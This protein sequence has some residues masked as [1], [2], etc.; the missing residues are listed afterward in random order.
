VSLLGRSGGSFFGVQTVGAADISYIYDELG[1]LRAVVDPNLDTAVYNY[2]AVGN[3]LSITRQSSATVSIIEFTPDSGPVGTTVTIFGTGFSATPSQNSVT[4]NGISASVT[5]STSTQIVTP[6][7][8]GATT[9]VI[10]V[11]TPG[12]SATSAQVFTVTS[13]TGAPTITGFTPTIGLA[14]T[15][16]TVTGTN[17]EIVPSNNVLKFNQTYAPVTSPTTTSLGTT[18]PYYTASGPI[19]VTTPKGKAVS[20]SDFFI[21]PAPYTASDVEYT[22]RIVLDGPS[23]TATINTANKVGLVV[24]DA[25]AGQTVS[26]GVNSSTLHSSSKLKLYNPNGI[27]LADNGVLLN[28]NV[29]IHL[30][31]AVTGTYTIL[32]DPFTTNTGSVTLTLSSEVNAGTILVD[33]ASVTATINRVGQR[34]RMTFSGTAGQFVSLGVN[35]STLFNNSDLY[36]Y[37]PDGSTL[38]SSS[39]LN[40]TNNFHLTLPAT[41]TYTIIVDPDQTSTGSVTLTLSSEVDAG[42]IVVDG[43]SVAATMNRVGQRARMTFSGTVGQVASLGINSTTLSTGTDLFVLKPDGTTLASSTSIT[44]TSTNFHLTLPATGTYNILIDPDNTW[45]GNM[46]LTLSSEVNVG[47]LTINDPAVPVTISRVGQRARATFSGTS[48]QQV[49]ARVTGSTMGSVTVQMLKPD[50]T[51]QTTGTSPASS[52]NLATQTLGTTGTYTILVDPGST[53]TG[54]LNLRVT[55]P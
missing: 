33:G 47:V 55:S 48:G 38:S 1:R 40:T 18:V 26:L 3:L 11:T 51:Q 44:S 53:N 20:S 15:A 41:G 36:I 50:G 17:F 9:G 30:T 43:A 19:S 46:T 16:V 34:A 29:N 54:S 42:P 24:F 28:T 21:P 25:T 45:T 52:F 32:V 31:P 35:S 23:L 2:D 22:G 12:G 6:V 14:G 7:P 37:K 13:D 49:T 8:A 5:S 27:F 10:G 4:F 39:T